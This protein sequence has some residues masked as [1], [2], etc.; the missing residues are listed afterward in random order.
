MK[1]DEFAQGRAEGRRWAAQLTESEEHRKFAQQVLAFEE[2]PGFGVEPASPDALGNGLAILHLLYDEEEA[3][4]LRIRSHIEGMAEWTTGEAYPTMARVAGFIEGAKEVLS[5]RSS[6]LN[7]PSVVLLALDEN[8]IATFHDQ[9]ADTYFEA[10]MLGDVGE[11]GTMLEGRRPVA[12]AVALQRAHS[13]AK[14]VDDVTLSA[15][16]RAKLRKDV[17]LRRM[18]DID[19]QLG[20]EP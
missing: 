17:A 19:R 10:R 6:S 12:Q 11:A 20:E 15:R 7:P 2:P 1:D 3:D 14:Q 16:F 13:Y 9:L 8:S 4:E 5:E 18:N